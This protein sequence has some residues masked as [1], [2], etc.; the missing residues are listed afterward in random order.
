[1]KINA[2]INN[3]NA[4]V[5]FA[6]AVNDAVALFEN[7]FTNNVTLNITFNY[8]VKD[9]GYASSSTNN[10]K[11][12]VP[13]ANI[14]TALQG[15]NDG[16]N[17]LPA[18]D[19]FATTDGAGF[20][21]SDAEA[22]VLGL[23]TD[24]SDPANT[25]LDG[26]VTMDSQ[27]WSFDPSTVGA[28]Q[29]DAVGALEHEISEVMGRSCGL[30]K[31]NGFVASPLA[32]F[33]YSS[34]G[35]IATSTTPGSDY[36]STDG[37]ATV[38]RANMGEG[39]N[40][41]LADWGGAASTDCFGYLGTGIVSGV[42]NT[43]ITEMRALGWN[44]TSELA[45]VHAVS[46]SQ[47][48]EA[49]GAGDQINFSVTNNGL[50]DLLAC[51]VGIYA[52]S[53]ATITTADTLIGTYALGSIGYGQTVA[54]S[55]SF[56][57]PSNLAL[58]NHYI[59]VIVDYNNQLTD[60]NRANNA[61][62]A[63]VVTIAPPT[64]T[65]ASASNGNWVG[66]GWLSKGVTGVPGAGDIANMSVT[67][68]PYTVLADD[69][70]IT[71]TNYG[72][73]Y[74][75]TYSVGEIIL[76]VNTT[77]EIAADTFDL[78]A[79][80]QNSGNILVDTTLTL[81]A[82][83]AASDVII[84]DATSAGH[85]TLNDAYGAAS[86]TGIAAGATLELRGQTV[87]GGG[88]ITGLKLVN[89]E[90]S[91]VNATGT[92]NELVIDTG[93]SGV[94]NQGVLE[95]TG[96]SGLRIQYTIVNQAAAGGLSGAIAAGGPHAHVDLFSVHVEGGTLNTSDNGVIQ[97]L[98]GGSILD[99]STSAGAVTNTGYVLAKDGDH[100]T[101]K[102]TI[103]N[104][105][106]IDVQTT[107]N[108]TALYID[109]TS[110][111]MLDSGG[112]SPKGKVV[113]NDSGSNYIV[114][115]G[116]A[117][118]L[119]NFDNTISGAGSFQNLTI[120][121][122]A[123]GVI[124]ATGASNRLV[125]DSTDIL[126]NSGLVEATGAAGLLLASQTIDAA[127]GGTVTPASGSH[128]DL[129]SDRFLGGTLA[130]SGAFNLTDN[131]N[132]L[133]GSTAS[134]A[135]TLK[136]TLAAKDGDHLTLKGTIHNEGEIDVQTTNNPTALYI[137]QTSGATLDSGGSSPKGKVVLNDSGSNYIESNGAATTLTNVDNTISG[138]GSFQNLTIVNQ[139][140]GVID[141]TGA[142]NRLVIDSTDILQNSGLV[143]ATG[144]A[145][146]LLASQTI[147]AALGGTVT[148]ASGSH[149]DLQSDRFLGGTLAGGGAFNLT[150]NGNVLDGSTASGAVT[151]K[152]TLAAKDGDHLTLK[153]TI[154][155]EGEIDVQTTNNPT[156]LYIDQTSGATLDSGG[157]SPKGKVV[158]N[159]SG[160]NYIE[161]NGAATTLTNVDNTISGAGSF[162]NLTIVNQ[163]GGV[164]D[165]TGASNRL[166]IDSTDILQNS[167]LVE[168]TG[169]AG[170]LLASQTID[171]ALGGTVTP[172]GGSHIDLQSDRFLGGTL[173]GSGAFNLTDNGNVL[174]GSTASGAVTLKT[175]LAAKDGDHL[176][177]KGTI[178]N[179]GE[180]DVQTTN[181]PT[182]LYIDQ[183]SGATLDSG[184][185]SPKGK[186]VLND[187]GSNY[188]ESNGAATTLTNVDN[189]ISGAGSFQNLT[190]VNQAGGVI[191]ATGAINQLVINSSDTLT[192]SGLIEATGAAGLSISNLT[193]NNAGGT[194]FAAAG[195]H[196]DLASDLIELGTLQTSGSGVIN[197]T[198]SG[199]TLTAENVNQGL[200]LA[201]NIQVADGQA[202]VIVGSV[203]NSGAVKV[204][205][206]G[207]ATL[208]IGATLDGGGKVVLF[209]SASTSVAGGFNNVSDTISGAG[210]ISALIQQ[211]SGGVIDATASDNALT[212]AT[213][214]TITSAGTL[215]ANGG[216]LVVQDAVAGAGHA[217]VTGGGSLSFAS[218]FDQNVTFQGPGANSLTLADTYSGTIS[219][220]A[221]GDWI[222]LDGV[223]ANGASLSTADSLSV[224]ENGAVVATLQLAGAYSGIGFSA[225]TNAAGAKIIAVSAATVNQYLAN[226]AFYDAMAGGFFIYDSATKIVA[227]LSALA[228]DSH[229]V[230][231][232]ASGT[233]TVS[234]SVFTSGKTALDKI[235]GGFVVSDTV[236]KVLA[237]L[238]A[239]EADATHIASITA[240]GGSVSVTVATFAA[241][242]GALDKITG[243]FKISDTVANVRANLTALQ[244]DAAHIAAITATGG[245][246]SVDM[247]TFSANQAA[248]D[249]I[250]GGFAI[251]DMASNVS[252]GLDSLV[253]ANI[254]SITISDNLAVGVTIAQLTSDATAISKLA[255]LNAMP[256]AFA[257]TDNAADVTAALNTLEGL[258][259]ASIT[260]SDNL[261]IGII[262]AQLTSDAAAI[263]KLMNADATPVAFAVTDTASDITAALDVLEGLNLASITISDNG[264]IG[265]MVAQLTSDATAIGKLKNA[266]ATS[267]TLAVTD[268]AADIT[269]GLDG[270]NG[271]KIVSITISDNGAVGASVAQL[272]QR[273]C[274]DRQAQERQRD[275]VSARDH[276]SAAAVTAG[277]AKLETAAAA[278]HIASITASGGPVT[279]SAAT[280]LADKA[281][282][283]TI[284]GGVRD[285][286]RFAPYRFEPDGPRRRRAHRLDR[287]DQRRR[288]VDE[289]NVDRRAGLY[290]RLG[291]DADRFGESRLFRRAHCRRRV[292]NSRSR[293]A[294]R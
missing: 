294:T 49:A 192:N 152:T 92:N 232:T 100:L 58:G 43:D 112:S 276:D 170:L 293:P 257:V 104:E 121:N 187:S 20:I 155:N 52:S 118:T 234:T 247:P 32:L 229:L 279:V 37:G 261:A 26:I 42:N 181:N 199:T 79:S 133:D 270:L 292:R 254:K 19:P 238:G 164:I 116:A 236:A 145:G 173:A 265:V 105:G 18:K 109:Q 30:N 223:T 25:N 63:A 48:K 258:N 244:A 108:P 103:H 34:S 278:G 243:G 251:S 99:G 91:F 47:T 67:G 288:D 12:Y 35:V 231:I 57:L 82:N 250:V 274:G 194:L 178:H 126:Q 200:H 83:G 127:L 206:T 132:V 162:Q 154:H 87:Q 64:F 249:K 198:D 273:R 62:G 262:V 157:S 86:L 93:A 69:V 212:L 60:A 272:D 253:D 268:N 148:P 182:A 235:V 125:I 186:V 29:Y 76:G 193:L 153:G 80:A 222:E 10:Y 252:T 205:A 203:V 159:D 263:G 266:N 61:S 135:V 70:T 248:L 285:F 227:N 85:V 84:S 207:G 23:T 53:D 201:A 246:V 208:N 196:I 239:L 221:V 228:A 40:D 213:G 202:L 147:D 21:V 81:G 241:D 176:T 214:T 267:A 27:N 175:T 220:F 137:D 77:L 166:V 142:S 255:N 128:I 130:G 117:T 120:V 237:N 115:N 6:T 281:A 219:G 195:S 54:E 89:S 45:A 233:V 179:E 158:L 71:V 24:N 75:N 2:T 59:G 197:I 44:P 191:D 280:A 17:F 204:G 36:F 286:R 282:L 140:G 31:T 1:M 185:S 51:T 242:Q 3:A 8:D 14:K 11:Y 156:A 188:I 146:L 131:G 101:L 28:T 177:L 110:G 72:T 13:Y 289:R 94:Q 88:T 284:V 143:E 4:P 68:S 113:L 226:P 165:A 74:F 33:R 111:A 66:T 189:T 102:G 218:T 56:I 264:A 134:G 16:K 210:T 161:S 150:D 41:D 190:I 240:T 217:L 96:S 180:I 46:L 22:T 123:G 209:D 7:T 167:G 73:Q 138:A 151:L 141:A 215:E 139:A 95:A 97:T 245:T 124:D 169:A 283:D 114:S 15:V 78:G 172:A 291:N 65:W 5:G 144:A 174:D 106:E 9:P 183:T 216:A 259:L 90:D 50:G 271:S 149:I 211:Q 269:A 256:V 224:T 107:N 136:T 225:V 287:G 122:Q 55:A 184:G 230:S 163:A 275:A 277:L 260:I 160:S 38:M 168:A 119:T 98:D 39:A 171:A 290:A 129:Q